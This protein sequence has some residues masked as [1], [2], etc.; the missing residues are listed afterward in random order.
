MKLL[1]PGITID[2]TLALKNRIVMSRILKFDLCENSSSNNRL[3]HMIASKVYSI[4]CR[5]I[6]LAMRNNIH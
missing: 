2:E 3:Q 1:K 5:N 4:R 6:Q